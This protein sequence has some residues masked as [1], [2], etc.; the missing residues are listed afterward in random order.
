MKKIYFFVLLLPF[1]VGFIGCVSDVE[2]VLQQEDVLLEKLTVERVE[3][4]AETRS[5][6][7]IMQSSTLVGKVIDCATGEPIIGCSIVIRFSDGTVR[8]TMTDQDGNYSIDVPSG[9]YGTNAI[10]TFSFVGYIS[11]SFYLPSILYPGLIHYL[12]TVC[13][14]SDSSILLSIPDL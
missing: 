6:A 7:S 2:D 11:K 1:M 14:E 13:L 3:Q 12:Q 9:M 8:G 10:I 5:N 4:I